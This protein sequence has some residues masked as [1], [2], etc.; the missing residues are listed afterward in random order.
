VNKTTLIRATIIFVILILIGVWILQRL[1]YRSAIETAEVWAR[2][3]SIR[4]CDSR[5][6]VDASGSMFT[7]QFV[8]EFSCESSKLKQWVNDSIGLKGAAVTTSN[9]IETYIISPG[10]GAT[11][12]EVK[13]NWV[14]NTVYLRAFWS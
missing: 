8:V 10:G 3:A 5:P 13:I 6:E 11:F 12:A 9:N 4:A 2:V 7:R 14:E 1:N